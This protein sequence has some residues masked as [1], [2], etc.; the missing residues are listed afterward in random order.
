MNNDWLIQ[1]TLMMGPI[2]KNYCNCKIQ[3]FIIGAHKKANLNR[4]TINKKNSKRKNARSSNLGMELE[5]P[6]FYGQVDAG[7]RM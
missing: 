6:P 7:L 1:T 4:A 2:L 5:H 3:C